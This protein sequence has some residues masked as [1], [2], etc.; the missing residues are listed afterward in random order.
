[1]PPYRPKPG[2]YDAMTYRRSGS[3]GVLLP[4]VSLGLWHNFGAVDPF[5]T[6][7]ATVRRAFDLGITHFDLANNYGPPPGSAEITF[8]KILKR[9]LRA[10][11]DEL[12][13]STKA[14][15]LMWPG[16]YG[17][18]GS[19][20]YLLASLDQSLARMQLDYVDIFYHHR[21]D[22]DTPLE[23]TM[24]ALADAVRSGRALYAGISSYPP[25]LT[26]RAA[27]ILATHGTPCLIHQPKYSMLVREIERG[28]LTT[29][30]E[31]GIGCI[32][33]SPLAQGLLTDRYFKGVPKGSRAS[34]PHGFLKKEQ[35]T[36]AVR[37]KVLRLNDI[38]RARGQTLAQMAVAWT[39]RHPS[40]TSA[41]IGASRPAHVTDAV[42][43]LDNTTFSTEELA[44]IETILARP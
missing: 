8:G 21:P 17:D 30:Q 2:R 25:D 18:W 5:A 41:V 20:K 4:A 35:V 43:A 38:A 13:V 23:E 44:A 33:F 34:K 7:R 26:R 36:E 10:H 29:L 16:P 22:P 9:D 19:R 27:Q 28:L 31:L 1:M 37:S 32:V 12:I 39:L 3:S 6:A 15:Y 40:V 42:G 24:G 14:G 11:R